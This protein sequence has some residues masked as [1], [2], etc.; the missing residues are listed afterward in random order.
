MIIFLDIDGTLLNDHAIMPDSAGKAVKQ[1][2]AAGHQ[3]YL[4]T[5]E[6]LAEIRQRDLCEADG[7]IGANGA[8]VEVHGTV[9]HHQMLSLEEER[10]IVDFCNE[11]KTGIILESNSGLYCNDVM[12]EEGSEVLY[13]DILK[14]TGDVSAAEDSARRYVGGMTLLEG[15]DL[16]RDDINK[17]SFLLHDMRDHLDSMK[18]F[19]HLVAR[20]WGTGGD[21]P[22]FGDLSPQGVSKENGIRVLLN[23]LYASKEDCI[24]FGDAAVDIPMFELCGYAVA[25]GNASTACRQAA[26]YV[27]DDVDHD[28]I[29]KAFLHLGLI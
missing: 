5:G 3:V 18:E 12:K 28:G 1:A 20:T 22:L 14:R 16:Y 25:I 13:E 15:T 8:Y 21:I 10:R 23:C 7:I 6:A 4:C 17:V 2:R 27:T 26:D 9:I 11:R 19:P 29:Y 24:A